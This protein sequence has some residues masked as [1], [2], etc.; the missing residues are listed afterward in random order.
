MSRRHQIA[1]QAITFFFFFRGSMPPHPPRGGTC[2]AQS[3]CSP[4]FQK[5][6]TALICAGP[7]AYDFLQ[8]NLSQVLPCLLTVQRIVHSEYETLMYFALMIYPKHID[9]YNAPRLIS[10]GEDATR[11]ISRVEYDSETVRCVGFVLPL[12]N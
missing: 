6:Y 12:N 8:N 5:L 4:N 1:S 10:V 7:L 2:Y 9:I 11:V 3:N